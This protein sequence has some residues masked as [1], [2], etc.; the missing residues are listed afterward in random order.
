MLLACDIGNS[1]I[2]AGIFRED[3][4]VE[5]H[6]LSEIKELIKLVKL[7]Q[8]KDIV[9]SSVVPSKTQYLTNSLHQLKLIPFIIN[10]DSSFNLKI[11][12]DRETLGIDRICSAEGSYYLYCYKKEFKKNQILISIDMG[13]ATTL[14]IIKYPGIFEGGIIA[15]GTELMFK[16]LKNETAQLPIVKSKNYKNIIGRTTNES[17]ASGVMH[18]AAGLIERA[19]NLVKSQ[20]GAE[21]IIIYIT[22]GNFE[23][24]KPFLSF[25]YVYEKAL[26]LHGINAIFKKNMRTN[27][28]SQAI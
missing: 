3:K 17:I 23:H 22:G 26:V 6:F 24:I 19:I 5:F 1:N 9:V 16:S 28:H 2:K 8:L 20:T 15:P 10:K 13:T 12:Y 4:L 18:S 7:N 21:E 11:E 25:K 14:N 27:Q